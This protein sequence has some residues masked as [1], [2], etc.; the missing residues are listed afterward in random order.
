MRVSNGRLRRITHGLAA[1]AVAMG[2]LLALLVS[3]V[4]AAPAHAATA[5]LHGTVTTNTSQA[6]VDATVEVLSAG[7]TAAS[8]QTDAGGAYAVS[9]E[10]GTYDV[11]VTPPSGS[12]YQ[13]STQR[14]V[15][16]VGDVTLNFVLVPAGQVAL[17]GVLRDGVG[18]PVAG[19]TIL[20]QPV[21]GGS[22]MQLTTGADGAYSYAVAPGDYV[23]SASGCC[24][25]GALPASWNVTGQTLSL[26]GDTALDLDLPYVPVTVRVQDPAGSPVADVAVSTGTGHGVRDQLEWGPGLVIANWA[27]SY[28]TWTTMP[29]TDVAGEVVLWLPLTASWSSFTITAT[30]P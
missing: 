20:L 29:T 19:A 1:R 22:S 23:L 12:E 18:D 4:A 28:P 26:V 27:A 30:P 24:R 5:S 6:I 2:A 8:G 14:D 3:L 25:S 7:V 11:R 17:S 21:G 16:M 9:V 10:D 15:S 13:V